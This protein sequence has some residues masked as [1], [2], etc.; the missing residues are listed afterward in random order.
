MVTPRGRGATPI[1]PGITVKGVLMGRIPLATGELVEEAAIVDLSNAYKELIKRENELRPKVKRLRGMHYRS[2][3]TM[4]KF[5]QLLH[6]VVLVREEP[7]LYPPPGGALYRVEKPDGIRVAVSTRKVFKL[8]DVGREDDRCWTNLTRA[9]KE[10][11]VPPLAIEYAPPY[12]RPPEYE[13]VPKPPPKPPK[14]PPVGF[15]PYKWVP[16]PSMRQFRLLLK[17]LR[18]LEE[19]GIG[20]PG[21]EPEVDRLSQQ[22]GDWLLEIEDDL[23]DAKAIFHAEAIEKLEKWQVQVT[24]TMEGLIDRDLSRAVEGLEGLAGGR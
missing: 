16:T 18:I 22:I 7:M 6:L 10:G 13:E 11:W 19:L 15:T 3:Y 24:K 21:V 12:V 5:A 2:F 4:F 8:S 9:W 14:V 1:R 20:A 23:A 17:H